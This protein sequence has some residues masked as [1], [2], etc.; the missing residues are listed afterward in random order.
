VQPKTQY[1]SITVKMGNTLLELPS[2]AFDNLY[3]PTLYKTK[4]YYDAASHTLYIMSSNS[5]GAGA[6]E[7]VW[8]IEAGEYKN[9]FIAYGF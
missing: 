8:E 2:T 9:R 4:A 5:D 7:I 3:Q 6:Y 1:N